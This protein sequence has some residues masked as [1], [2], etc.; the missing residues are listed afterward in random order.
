MLQQAVR[1]EGAVPDR[2]VPDRAVPDGAV[3]DRA[4]PDGAAPNAQGWPRARL[5][6]V[7]AAILAALAGGYGFCAIRLGDGE[8]A[9]LSYDAPEMAADLAGALDIWFGD[10]PV[11]GGDLA[12]MRAGLLGAIGA[13]DVLGLPRARQYAM[14]RRYRAV[15]PGVMRGL[16]APV[17]VYV[18]GDASGGAGALPLI[19]DAA[20][21]F[22]LQW[23]GGL[24]L[25]LGAAR[26]VWLVGCRDVAGPLAE[27]L[28]LGDVRWVAVRGE[29]AFPGRCATPHWP[30]GHAAAL[31]ALAQV[32]PGDLVLVGAGVLGKAYCAQAKAMGAVGLDV[33][34]VFDGWAGVA[35]RGAFA[36]PLMGS[37]HCTIAHLQ[38][39]PQSPAA[40][41]ARLQAI[42]AASHIADGRF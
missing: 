20:L 10:D 35:S 15:L 42:I 13:A 2:A 17:G 38:D 32:A 1:P 16:G 34:S 31:A 3:P 19:A 4:V 23:S 30:K 14:S 24:A 37:G 21:H 40:A 7:L 18:A 27:A 28:G 36:G 8:G 5:D 22:Y 41:R 9:L 29:A 39:R 6:D 11:S 33:G 12:A 26:R 25:A